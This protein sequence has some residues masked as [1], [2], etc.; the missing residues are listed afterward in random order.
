MKTY[1]KFLFVSFLK[2]FLFIFIIIFCLIF[3]L[4]LLSEIDFFKEI[5]VNYYFP[6]FLSFLNSP[7]LLFEMFPFIILLSA[8]L[9]FVNIFKE[10]QIEIFKYS[11]LKNFDLIKIISILTLLIGLITNTFY[12]NFSS[13]LKNFY[14]SLKSKYTT[15][16]KY[17]AVIT[18]NGLWIK[19]RI[20]EKIFIINALEVSDNF[21]NDA[22]ISE[23][24]NKFNLIRNIKSDLIN[25]ESKKWI[26]YDAI[27]F[28]ENQKKIQKILELNSNF[29]YKQIQNLFSN[30]SSLSITDLLKLKKNYHRLGYSTT[31]IDI[32]LLKIIVF[33][34]YLVLMVI[35]SSVLML[36]SKRLKSNTFKISMGLFFS[37]IIYYIN[38]FFYVMGSTEKISLTL[39]IM[40]PIMFLSVINLIILNKI[41]EK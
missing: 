38:N 17:L 34:I 25:I 32:H 24:D 12:Y 13:N 21:L 22:F 14:L 37:V 10:N 8:Q 40:A 31:E 27:I 15:D 18:N 23:F 26:V 30:L 3:I 7:S 29:D 35:F 11:G 9:F 5:N 36:N 1:I 4:N 41:N 33:P 6:I 28:E 19:D 20:N 2:S 16:D 39:A